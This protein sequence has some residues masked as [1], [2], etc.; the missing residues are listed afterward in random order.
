LWT[1][2][3]W[4]QSVCVKNFSKHDSK[5]LLGKDWISHKTIGYSMP[6]KTAQTIAQYEIMWNANLMQQDNFINI[7]S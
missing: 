3:R 7:Y 4:E 1:G 5:F 2:D 6:N